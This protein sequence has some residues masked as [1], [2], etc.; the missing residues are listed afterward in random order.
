MYSTENS[1]D[2]TEEEFLNMVNDFYFHNIWAG[3]KL[4]RGELWC[5]KMSVDAYLKNH[6]LKM[7]EL[8]CHKVNGTD[9]WHDGRFIDKW[10]DDFI[11]HELKNCFAHYET[12]DAKS[13]LI[14]THHLFAKLAREVA[15]KL[16]YEYPEQ[17]EKCAEN[18]LHCYFD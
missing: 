7:T 1:P 15:N 8:Y 11:L 5:A 18:F 17:A 16:D 2:M 6:L 3:K 13:A 12:E 10:A 14:S 4:L 9:V